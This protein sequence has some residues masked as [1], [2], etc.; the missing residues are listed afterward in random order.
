MT[1][2]DQSRQQLEAAIIERASTDPAFRERLLADPKSTIGDFLGA[3]LPPGMKITVLV[4]E[5]GHHY[6]VLPP[7]TPDVEALPL[8]ELELAL[9]GGGRTLRPFPIICDDT[10][11]VGQ[12]SQASTRR[13]S[14]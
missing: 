10:I 6:L 5:P 2:I 1:H 3:E 13:S 4:E 9:V 11:L 14:C 7:A 8:D 12:A